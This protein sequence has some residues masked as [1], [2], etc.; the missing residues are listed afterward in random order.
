MRTVAT[1]SRH[2]SSLPPTIP[3]PTKSSELGDEALSTDKRG[4]FARAGIVALESRR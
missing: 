1:F 3:S 2:L 4:V